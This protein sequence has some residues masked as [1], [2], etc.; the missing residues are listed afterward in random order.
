MKVTIKFFASLKEEV[1]CDEEELELGGGAS[2]SDLLEILR[3]TR[4]VLRGD[5]K[6]LVAV[7][8]VR[9]KLDQ[10]LV[11]GDVVALLPPVSG[12]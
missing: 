3:K 8:G 12:G 11:E 1:G 7:N 4:P 6:F 5:E 10:R 9:S 2:V